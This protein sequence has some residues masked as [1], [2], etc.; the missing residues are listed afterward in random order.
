MLIFF[1]AHTV[2]LTPVSCFSQ[3]WRWRKCCRHRRLAPCSPTARC[4]TFIGRIDLTAVLCQGC[5]PTTDLNT[6]L[7]VVGLPGGDSQPCIS[8]TVTPSLAGREPRTLKR[9]FPIDLSGFDQAHFASFDLWAFVWN[10]NRLPATGTSRTQVSITGGGAPAATRAHA[11]AIV[12]PSTG[13]V[14][15]ITIT[16]PGVFR[17]LVAILLISCRLIPAV[18][19]QVLD[20]PRLPLAPS[21]RR[22]RTCGPRANP[23]SASSRSATRAR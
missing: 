14:T 8:T 20:T 2:F 11:I 17:A 5:T 3:P 1:A 10:H 12:D 13:A 23:P 15:G 16:N 19:A 4:V 18:R 21:S 22:T 7:K 9:T 6:P